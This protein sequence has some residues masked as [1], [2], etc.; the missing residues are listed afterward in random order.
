MIPQVF[1][2]LFGVERD[3]CPEVA[4]EE[5]QDDVTGPCSERLPA[6]KVVTQR[7]E[8]IGTERLNAESPLKALAITVKSNP[9]S[10]IKLLAKMIGITPD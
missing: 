9:G 1:R 4:K 2:H 5:N 6:G 8:E 10:M 7:F 3:R